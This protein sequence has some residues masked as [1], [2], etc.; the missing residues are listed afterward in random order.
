[1]SI[2][3]AHII[4][5]VFHP[6]QAGAIALIAILMFAPDKL[7]P[8]GRFLGKRFRSEVIRRTG[9][10]VLIPTSKI[11]PTSHLEES[12]K[13]P[14]PEPK[15]ADR[16]SNDLSKVELKS[17]ASSLHTTMLVVTVICLAGFI[18]WMLLH[19]R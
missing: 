8:I 4:G 6:I 11:S 17:D 5:F 14:L 13:K 9:L 18:F 12:V 15:S 2:S 10:S 3:L 19:A 7:G 16:Q 1:M